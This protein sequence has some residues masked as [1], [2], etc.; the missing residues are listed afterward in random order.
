MSY[1][2][3][4]LALR[5]ERPF[6]L[7]R[8]TY[9]ERTNVLVRLG[10][11]LGE[12]GL[13]SFLDCSL[14]DVLEYLRA[15][16]PVSLLRG[17]EL[18]IES[19]LARLPRGPAPAR[20][21]IDVALHD[22]WARELD[23]PLWEALG[24]RLDELPP[25]AATIGIQDDED[26]LR[27]IVREHRGWP[28]LKLKLGAGDLVADE[29]TVIVVREETQA[30]LYVDANG[31]WSVD[32]AARIVPRLGELGVMFIEQPIADRDPDAWRFLRG[33]LPAG[34]P[35]LVAD[36][37]IANLADVASFAGAADGVNV[38]LTKSGGLREACRL[39]SLARKLDMKVLIGCTVE[40]SLLV[41]AAA[42]I[43][44]LADLV[45]LDAHLNVADDPFVG[46]TLHLG[47]ILLPDGPGLGVT[48]R[49]ASD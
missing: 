2:V 35:L 18:S 45:D 40:S 39:I 22:I 38:K 36:E 26:R 12:G 46:M 1:A 37:S 30:D 25:S 14:D 17:D 48:W 8:G 4:P 16:D 3:E 5:L 24:L 21:A 42:H 11:G 10:E 31:G 7:S 33:F 13:A 28:V 47:R 32:E 6:R 29:R 15:V 34:V 43:A 27:E 23:R 19:A 44:P 49:A 9:T 20:C 41:T